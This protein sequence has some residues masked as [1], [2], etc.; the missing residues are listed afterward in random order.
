MR[1]NDQVVY[2]FQKKHRRPSDT[3]PKIFMVDQLW[4]WVLGKDLV[5]TSFPQRWQ[6]PRNDPLNVLEGIIEDINSKTREPVQN[7]YEL[8]MT[9]TGRCF[10][11][12]DRHRKADD[13]YQFMDM[14]EASIGTAMDQEAKLFREFSQASR[15]ASA[16]LKS[17][18]RPTKFAR[19]LEATGKTH[20]KDKS[21]VDRFHFD[22]D[23]HAHEPLFV[24]KLLDVGAETDLLA[25]IKD[26]R[27]V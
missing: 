23:A 2:R 24:D 1:D 19:T 17:H 5:V 8:V 10:G 27:E 26:I 21:N 13:E 14:F 11:T 15:Q 20:E 4:M 25:E 7:V 22:D 12:F 3:D 9:I 18:S 16:W 6:Q